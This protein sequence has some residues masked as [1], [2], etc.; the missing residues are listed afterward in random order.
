M[1]ILRTSRTNLMATGTVTDPDGTAHRVIYTTEHQNEHIVAIIAPGRLTVTLDPALRGGRTGQ[2]G[3]D[4]HSN[5]PRQG[6]RGDVRLELVCPPHIAGVSASPVTIAAGQTSGMLR[7]SFAAGAI[8]PFNM[9]LTG[10][11]H[12]HR[13][14]RLPGRGRVA[15]FRLP[16]ALTLDVGQAAGL[17]LN[18]TGAAASAGDCHGGG[19]APSAWA[20]SIGLNSITIAAPDDGQTDPQKELPIGKRFHRM[21]IVNRGER[22]DD[23]RT[24]KDERSDIDRAARS[25]IRRCENDEQRSDR[26]GNA[27]ERCPTR[28][29]WLEV[30]VRP[31]AVGSQFI[32]KIITMGTNTATRK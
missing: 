4:R 32:K 22:V 19:L 7:L 14:P 21:E 6:T 11:G 9:P 28:P 16:A 3:D 18:R 27:G 30:G 8:G 23:R 10:P 20:S 2:V 13:Q 5:E 15:A 24:G 12:G 17:P 29:E 31:L 25:R 26:S 1:E